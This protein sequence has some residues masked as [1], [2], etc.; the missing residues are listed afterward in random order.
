MAPVRTPLLSRK[1]DTV[2]LVWF[3]LHLAV[4]LCVDLVSLYPAWLQ[5]EPLLQLRKWYIVTYNDRFFINPPAWFTLFLWIEAIY[6]VPLSVWAI[7]ALIR[8]KNI[9]KDTHYSV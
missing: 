2:Y 3:A 7:F 8:G 9:S 6:H 5:P 4:M 1:L